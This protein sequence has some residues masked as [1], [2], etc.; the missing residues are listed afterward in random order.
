MCVCDRE[1]QG[2]GETVL[3]FPAEANYR[4]W[5]SWGGGGRGSESWHSG[6]RISDWF[7]GVV[8]KVWGPKTLNQGFR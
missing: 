1:D 3:D 7:G 6:E 2:G 4:I 5:G 8:W